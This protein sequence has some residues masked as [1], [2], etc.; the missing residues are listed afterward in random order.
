[1]PLPWAWTI[2]SFEHTHECS[3]SRACCGFS[4][5][6]QER[7]SL[8]IMFGCLV[9]CATR[10]A[11]AFISTTTTE[12]EDSRMTSAG[13][14]HFSVKGTV[15]ALTS[16]G[17][18]NIVW[19][20]GEKGKKLTII[21]AEIK[22]QKY[23][24]STSWTRKQQ[25]CHGAHCPVSSARPQYRKQSSDHPCPRGHEASTIPSPR[26]PGIGSPA[27]TAARGLT[28]TLG[29]LFSSPSSKLS[30]PPCSITSSSSSITQLQKH[31]GTPCKRT[32]MPT[33]K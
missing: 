13:R 24:F 21:L 2:G 18:L 19:C 20:N 29:G 30:T 11:G 16:L 25:A 14:L 32:T 7:V 15:Y 3:T 1:M 22:Q 4:M 5:L 27:T 12:S 6:K 8:P 17:F 33:S 26:K 28:I 10:A 23:G 9:C 31:K